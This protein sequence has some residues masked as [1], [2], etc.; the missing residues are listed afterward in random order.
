[1]L[2]VALL[3]GCSISDS[4]TPAPV[5]GS[6]DTGSGEVGGDA[7]LGDSDSAVGPDYDT[8]GPTGCTIAADCEAGELCTCDG[9]CVVDLGAP[10]AEAKNCGSGTWCDLCTGQCEPTAALCETCTKSG[11]CGFDASC[12]P[13]LSGASVCG[14]NCLTD[15]GCTAGYSCTPVSGIATSQCVPDTGDCT[16]LGLCDDSGDCPEAEKC[17]QKK[18]VPGCLEDGSC[19]Q[20]LVCVAADCVDPCVSDEDCESPATCEADGHCRAPGWCEDGGGCEAGDH[21]DKVSH[22][23]EPGC[24]DDADCQDAAMVCESTQ[25]VSKGC[26][27]N[28]QCS[29]GEECDKP[30]AAC[31]PTPDPHCATCDASQEDNSGAC[32]SAEALCVTLQDQDEV[33]QG[34][35]CLLPCSEDPIDQC[36][37]AYGCIHIEVP[38]AGIDG[39]FCTRECWVTPF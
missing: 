30:A 34:D 5:D 26:I 13:L 38:D 24:L 37:Q 18:C 33:E 21:C 14:M 23:C 6:G 11:A 22:L 15:A 20:G 19:S 17:L 9:A 39:W 3:V 31:V 10:C 12:V 32:G 16:D 35:F 8:T 29:F 25:C 27:H 7:S 1:M 28:Y 2:V 36:P 4:E